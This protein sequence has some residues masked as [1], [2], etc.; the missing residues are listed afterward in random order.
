MPKSVPKTKAGL[1]L[2][3]LISLSLVVLVMTNDPVA[4]KDGQKNSDEMVPVGAWKGQ[5]EPNERSRL[6]AFG[7]VV[8]SLM[9][10][11]LVRR[12]DT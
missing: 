7:L 4:G 10:V 8:L 11:I 9:C 3:L 2:F 12:T 5:V 6:P 1:A